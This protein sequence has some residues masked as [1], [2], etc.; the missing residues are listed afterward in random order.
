VSE[1]I[2]SERDAR[3]IALDHFQSPFRFEGVS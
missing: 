3:L 2:L 1:L